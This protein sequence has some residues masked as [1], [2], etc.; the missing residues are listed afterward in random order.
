MPQIEIR[1]AVPADAQAF[2][3]L[4]SV[5][6]SETEFLLFEPGERAVSLEEQ[7]NRLK[8]AS[9]S[10]FV[11]ILALEDSELD[12]IAGF[13]AGRRSE[14]QRDVHNLEL[15]L[16]IRQSHTR[17]GWGFHLLK[18]LQDWAK[19]VGVHR[20]ELSVMVNNA[21]AIKL[22]EKFGFKHEGTKRDAV[23]LKSGYVDL[24]IMAK[25]I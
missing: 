15:I 19:T 9:G 2:L 13:A 22:Y 20:L 23:R 21:R 6:D 18:E 1:P 3:D 7:E 10:D 25:L 12:S 14:L 24:H 5:L 16:A 8:N 4:W 17:N 11:H